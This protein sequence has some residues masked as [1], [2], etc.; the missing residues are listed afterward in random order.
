MRYSSSLDTPTHS[1][2]RCAR[3]LRPRPPSGHVTGHRFSFT[4]QWHIPALP[5]R[6]PRRLG[7]GDR[8]SFSCYFFFYLEP[9]RRRRRRE[10]QMGKKKKQGKYAARADGRRA[11]RARSSSRCGAAITS[12]NGGRSD[13]G[14]G[15]PPPPLHAP[16][17]S[18]LLTRNVFDGGAASNRPPAKRLISSQNRLFNSQPSLKTQFQEAIPITNSIQLGKTR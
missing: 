17:T 7:D 1:R 11:P 10:M 14:L 13:D 8:R 16:R 3:H 15:R 5:E 6:W 18:R 9:W 4:R 12:V 2:R